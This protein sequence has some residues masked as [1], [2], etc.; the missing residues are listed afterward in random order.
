MSWGG[1]GGARRRKIHKLGSW[2]RGF[3]RLFMAS[4]PGAQAGGSPGAGGGDWRFTGTGH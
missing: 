4:Y 2:L 3:L 1:G